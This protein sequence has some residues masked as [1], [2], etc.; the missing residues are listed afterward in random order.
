MYKAEAVP[1]GEDQL[2]HLEISREIARRFNKL[3]GKVF[4]EPSAILAEIP[5]L[6]GLDGRKMSKSYDNCI[7]LRDSQEE[8][9]EKVMSMITDP[10]RVRRNAPGHP[11]VCSVFAYHK[12]YNPE[13]V[14]QIEADCRAAA[15]GCVECKKNLAEKL[16]QTLASFHEQRNEWA[17][18]PDIVKDILKE[19][20][21][22]ASKIAKQ[23][24]DEVR[25][26]MRL[27]AY[28]SIYIA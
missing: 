10:A 24:M 20:A 13:E 3:Y 18:K 19:G 7:Y 12:L 23:T 26:A 14:P 21:S 9:A 16:S 4:P 17:S 5:N 6:P 25:T 2:P 1:V 28:Q 15:I 22:K 27:K 11:E 8:I